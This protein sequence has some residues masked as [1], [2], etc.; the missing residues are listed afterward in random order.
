MAAAWWKKSNLEEAHAL[1]KLEE[2][3]APE[4]SAAREGAREDVRA[5][6]AT[7]DLAARTESLERAS[8]TEHTRAVSL[9]IRATALGGW[10]RRGDP[11]ACSVF[12]ALAR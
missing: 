7:D 1:E 9:N 4:G 5:R 11:L 3:R 8:D 2:A 6:D 10:L 12:G